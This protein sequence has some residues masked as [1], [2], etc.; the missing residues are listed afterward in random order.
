MMLECV[1]LWV[2]S[3]AWIPSGSGKEFTFTNEITF[4]HPG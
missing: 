1:G 3:L 4:M 2:V